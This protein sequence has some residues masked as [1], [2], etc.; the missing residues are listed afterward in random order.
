MLVVIGLGARHATI[1]IRDLMLSGKTIR[2][3]TEGDATP[4]E[5]IPKLLDLHAQG[6]FPMEA[7]VRR[8]DARDIETAVADARSG[9]AIKPVL[10]W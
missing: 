6:K 3:C 10:V 1:D 5:F 4:A 9:E 2:G 7:I 8:Y